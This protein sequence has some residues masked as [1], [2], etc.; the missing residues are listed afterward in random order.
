MAVKIISI[1]WVAKL[2]DSKDLHKYGDS[3]DIDLALD[4]YTYG[5]DKS[6]FV[7]DFLMKTWERS[8][9]PVMI[10]HNMPRSKPARR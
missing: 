5:P 2:N 7:P 10:L 1:N 3:G 8:G 4:N 9:P 6:I